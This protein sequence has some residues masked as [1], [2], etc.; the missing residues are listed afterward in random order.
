M[1][2]TL[3]YF[4]YKTTEHFQGALNL[5]LPI[6]ILFYSIWEIDNLSPVV[7]VQEKEGEKEEQEELEHEDV[8]ILIPMSNGQFASGGANICLWG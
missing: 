1:F 8:S 5:L 7:V 2:F 6:S 3:F 4:N